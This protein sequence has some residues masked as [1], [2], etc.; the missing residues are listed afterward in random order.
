[1]NV[2]C[3]YRSEAIDCVDS[4]NSIDIAIGFHLKELL[5]FKS[6]ILSNSN[7]Y[8]INMPL[9]SRYEDYSTC[10]CICGFQ[11]F[12]PHCDRIKTG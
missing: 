10:N 12:Y 3:E 4:K 9:N 8:I 7:N 6:E 5:G 11:K 2:G 1:M